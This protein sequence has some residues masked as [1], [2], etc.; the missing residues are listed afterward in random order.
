MVSILEGITAFYK[1]SEDCS[2]NNP[3]LVSHCNLMILEEAAGIF[4][5]A[6]AQMLRAGDGVL[7]KARKLIEREDCIF[8]HCCKLHLQFSRHHVE[9]VKGSHLLLLGEG[10]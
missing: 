2:D 1:G 10:E 9:I 7:I 3:Y 5:D 6:P 8:Q 4:P